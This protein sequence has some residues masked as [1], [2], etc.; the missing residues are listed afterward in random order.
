MLITINNCQLYYEV[1]G[2]EHKETILF[3]HGGPGL[4]DCRGDV[5]SFAPLAST[6]RL[7][8]I[9]MRGSGRSQDVAPYTHD[10]WVED[11]NELRKHFGLN[12]IIIH[13]SSYGGFIAQEYVLKYQSHVSHA[14]FNV[15]SAN[16]EHHYAAI[17]NALNSN[18]PGID[19]DRMRRLF[20]GNVQSNDDFKDLYSAIMPL[21]AMIPDE[22]IMKSKLESIHFHYETHNYAFNQN[23]ATYNL[24]SRL[25]E[26]KVPVLVT[27]GRH[28]WITPIEC[29]EEIVANIPNARLV[30]FENNGHSLVRE[31]TEAYINLIKEFVLQA[32]VSQ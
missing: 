13:G 27:G 19:Q 15:T 9:D 16:N 6:Y 8:F 18:L 23:L 30:I 7:V 1:L 22:E 11:I 28:D 20:E 24:N 31:K 21:Y 3:I 25:H 5:L 29:S 10:Q 12:K 2:E 26:I 4:G 32:P 17:E 14:L